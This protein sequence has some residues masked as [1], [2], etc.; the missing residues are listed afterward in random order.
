MNPQAI[1]TPGGIADQFTRGLSGV[2]QAFA[3]RSRIDREAAR[4]AFSQQRALEQDRMAQA[5]FD[6]QNTWRQ[7]EID[8][9]VALDKIAAEKRAYDQQIGAAELFSK[10]ITPPNRDLVTQ[11]NPTEQSALGAFYR[12]RA[13]KEQA[14]TDANAKTSASTYGK[15]NQPK[16]VW[17]ADPITGEPVRMLDAP[18]IERPT[19]SVRPPSAAAQLALKLKLDA[20]LSKE[21]IR[22]EYLAEDTFPDHNYGMWQNQDDIAA[23]AAIELNRKKFVAD[24]LAK[25]R[26]EYMSTMTLDDSTGSETVAPSAS[27]AVGGSDPLADAWGQVK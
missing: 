23:Q 18:G 15:A 5:A 3:D 12:G 22:L 26:V 21:A 2:A 17:G 24:A 20:A 14:R 25:K 7:Q 10:G 1:M 16:M 11:M 19:P 9:Q 8:R 4:D 27:S 13:D 6:R